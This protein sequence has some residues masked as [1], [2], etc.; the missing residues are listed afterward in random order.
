MAESVMEQKV[1][2]CIVEY[3]KEH[4]YSPSTR[5]LCEMTHSASTSSVHRYVHNLMDKGKIETDHEFGT[6]R[7]LR[8]VGYEFRKL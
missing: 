3:I 7:A 2:D 1:F 5:D 8:V 6:P 4:G